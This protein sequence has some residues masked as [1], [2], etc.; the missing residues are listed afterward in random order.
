M[1]F[2]RSK[3][4]EFGK[5]AEFPVPI[6]NLLITKLSSTVY[7]LLFEHVASKKRDVDT[8]TAM[9]LD[10]NVAYYRFGGAALCEMLHV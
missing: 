2:I 8:F 1:N 7:N 9:S 6:S 3:W 4:L 10:G 5:S